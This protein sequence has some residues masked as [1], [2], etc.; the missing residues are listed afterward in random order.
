MFNTKE[1]KERSLGTKLF[2]KP[3]RCS[4]LKCVTTRRPQRPGVHGAKRRR[5]QLSEFG[6]QLKEKQKIKFSYGIREAQLKKIFSKA[7]KNP[8]I[9][10]PMIIS[11]LEQRLDNAVFRLGLALSRSVA[12]Q[13]VSHGHIV[14]NG[15]K[16]TIPSYQVKTGDVIA[17]RPQSKDHPAFQDLAVSLKNYQAPVWLSLDK[18]KLEGKVVSP[19]KDFDILFDV[20]LVVDYYSK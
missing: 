1:K 19:P 6:Q 12:R 17:I 2:L 18:E 13:L 4:S 15:S 5:G 3:Y 8:G 10:G 14:V 16:V 7:V 11:Y 20:S 9:T